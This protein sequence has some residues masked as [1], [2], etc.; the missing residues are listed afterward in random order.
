MAG[1]LLFRRTRLGIR[2]HVY[3]E[4]TGYLDINLIDE[5]S[6]ERSAAKS[7]SLLLSSSGARVRNLKPI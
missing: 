6:I 3:A 2:E 5:L 4:L 7:K 1:V